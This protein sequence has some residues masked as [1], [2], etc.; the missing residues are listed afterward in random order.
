MW[1]NCLFYAVN[2]WW[3]EGGYLVIMWSNYGWW[4]HIAWSP[5]LVEY[6][7]F[8]PP[9]KRRR[10]CPPWIFWGSVKR[11]SQADHEAGVQLPE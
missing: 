2:R 3:R 6:Y 4:P 10:W 11:W 9:T 7:E 1:S 5:D 8:C